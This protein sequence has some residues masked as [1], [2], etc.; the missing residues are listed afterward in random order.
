[1]MGALP[2]RLP[3]AFAAD[4]RRPTPLQWQQASLAHFRRYGRRMAQQQKEEGRFDRD[5]SLALDCLAAADDLE[6]RR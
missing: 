5:L 4:H 1:M 2:C 3:P 6:R